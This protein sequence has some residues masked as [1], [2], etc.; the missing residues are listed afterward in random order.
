MKFIYNSS[1]NSELVHD[2]LKA[3]KEIPVYKKGETNIA[4]NYTP[5]SLLSV[6]SK[7]LE[8]TMY[9]LVFSDF[10]K[11]NILNAHYFSLRK[12]I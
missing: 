5:I 3:A 6:F 9:N 2:Q 10:N 8:R 1:F 4:T 7:I 11:S 12:T